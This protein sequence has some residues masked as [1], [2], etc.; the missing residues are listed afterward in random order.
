MKDSLAVI[1]GRQRR[2]TARKNARADVRTEAGLRGNADAP[3]DRLT[4]RGVGLLLAL[5]VAAIGVHGYHPYVE[6]A[7]IYLPGIKKLLDPSLYPLNSGFFASHAGMTLFPNL[8]AASMRISHIP[9]D[10]ALLAWQFSCVFVLLLACWKIG[11]LV[12]DDPVA[13]WGGVA[14]VGSLLTIPVAGTAL[15]IMDQYLNTR[16]LS[17]ATVLMMVA[18]VGEQRYYRAG[19]WALFTAV[20]HPLM[21]VFGFTFA[22]ILVGMR[23][24]P[25]RVLEPKMA[26][27]ALLP[28][29]LFP[30]MSSVYHEALQSRS[31]FFLSRWAW[32]EWVGMLAPFAVFWGIGKLAKK[33]EMFE[34]EQMCTGLNIFG[35]I[36]A[37]ASLLTIPAGF[38]RFTLLQPMRYLH[39]TYVLMFVFAGG[40]LAQFFLRRKA[41]RWVVLFV[42]LCAGMFVTQRDLFAATPH[43]ELPGVASPNPWVQAFVWIRENA[44]KDAYFALNPEHSRI[45]GED[46]QGF[47]AIAER[48]MLADNNKDSGAATMFPKMAEA[49]KEHTMAQAGWEHLER[50]DFERLKERFGVDWVVLD[51]TSAVEMTCPYQNAR[52]KVCRI[53]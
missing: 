12:F 6:D 20:I 45:K 44:P 35:L 24:L 42:P 17:A 8:I 10:W 34:L 43:V 19:L 27:A 18:S 4:A 14:L 3:K 26:L 40:L 2:T 15:Y 37:A 53:E 46:Q 9:F 49:W 33:R 31:Y 13:R 32:F 22:V 7:E 51:K 16:S 1:E 41:W 21:F 36:F 50:A 25:V 28:A 11:R 30:P 52:V 47:R 23:L 48:S 5:T 38:E 39:L 29:A